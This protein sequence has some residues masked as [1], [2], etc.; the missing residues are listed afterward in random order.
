MLATS[1]RSLLLEGEFR[2]KIEASIPKYDLQGQSVAIIGLG[3]SGIAAA[4]LALARGASVLA[5]DQNETLKPLEQTIFNVKDGRLKT[6]LGCFDHELFD[7]ADLIVVSHGVALENY[8]LASLLQ[9]GKR[10][11]S[12]LDFAAEVL[13]QCTKVLAVTGTNGKSTVATFAGQM[14]NHSNIRTFV[15]GNLGIPLSEA[16]FECLLSPQEPYQAAV[17]EVSSYQLEIPNKFFS[18]SVSVILNLT[19]DHLERHK[20]MTN[21]S[22]IKCRVLSHMSGRKI[23]IL[24]MGNPYITDAIAS[25]GNE[26]MFAWIGAYPGIKVDM[27]Q[28]VANFNVPGIGLLSQL[29]LNAMKAVGTHNYYNAAIAALSVIGLDVGI[30]T[31][32]ISLTIDRLKAPPHRMQIVHEDGNGVT[33]VDD[34]KATNVEAT[35]AGLTGLKEKKAVVLLGGLSKMLDAQ[36]S[37]GFEHLIEPLKNHRGVVTVSDSFLLQ[38]SHFTEA[39]KIIFSVNHHSC[40]ASYIFIVIKFGS[41]GALIQDT[42]SS[43]GLAIPCLQAKDL[44]GA[45]SLAKNMA[46]PGD[47]IL[48]SPGC[49]SFDEF[50]NFEHRGNFF[51]E[52]D[53]SMV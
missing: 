47:V 27:E 33:W 24:P 39:V 28:K 30:D 46:K 50:I 42:L 37:N 16:A 7:E 8:C 19:P 31:A 40:L 36:G 41:S 45:V 43:H 48:L 6:I 15:G 51:Q 21:Y 13:P 52:L 29:P 26:Y 34:S 44:K 18:P 20:S 53:L 1:G 17:V 38:H 4:K 25:H 32:A 3:K 10:V 9:S 12:E 5:L 49:A 35:Y 11:I 22:M 14:L 2:P 23:A